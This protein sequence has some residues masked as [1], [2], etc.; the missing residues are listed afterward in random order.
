MKTEVKIPEK[1]ITETQENPVVLPILP[2]V[3]Q[4]ET[5]NTQTIQVDTG[6]AKDVMLSVPIENPSTSMV[7]V[8]TKP[9]GTK[10][11]VRK[12]VV[13]ET[14]LTFLANGNLTI[15]I[16]DNHKTFTDVDSHWASN[17][18]DFVSSHELYNGT[19]QNTFSPNSTMTRAMLV[20]VLHNRAEVAAVLM[21]F[22]NKTM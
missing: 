12:S 5:K 21:R 17:A 19:S 15:E 7:A 10:E 4:K 13:Q 9:D 8:V 2:V 20:Q 16:V 6:N 3:V 11:V 1:A 18:I 14:G 22:L